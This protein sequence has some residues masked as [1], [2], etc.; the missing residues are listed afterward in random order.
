MPQITN[1]LTMLYV[2]NMDVAIDFYVNKL[3]FKETVR[4]GNDW[5]EIAAPGATIALHPIRETTVTLGW[6]M[7]LGFAVT[8]IKASAEALKAKGV[9]VGFHEDAN[10][11]LAPFRD[12][13]GNQ[14]YLW[15]Y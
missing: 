3:G 12:P 6:N 15:S 7:Q 13:D 5:A 1:T 4:Y 14:L 10:V 9:E 11:K 2:S 8:D